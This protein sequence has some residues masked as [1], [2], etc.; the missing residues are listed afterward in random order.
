MFE[1][2]P[3][4]FKDLL[5]NDNDVLHYSSSIIFDFMNF[6]NFDIYDHY[7]YFHFN[8]GYCAYQ[9]SYIGLPKNLFIFFPGAES[10][11][12]ALSRGSDFL[13]WR[14]KDHYLNSCVFIENGVI[15]YSNKF[16]FFF[17]NFFDNVYILNICCLSLGSVPAY[18][19][20]M[21]VLENLY[22]FPKLKEIK[23]ELHGGVCL[24]EVYRKKLSLNIVK[25][26][27]QNKNIK[28]S[29]RYHIASYDIVPFTG[30]CILF[31][32]DLPSNIS[33]KMYFYHVYGHENKPVFNGKLLQN[34]CINCHASTSVKNINLGYFHKIVVLEN[35]FEINNY[36][37]NCLDIY[38]N[39]VCFYNFF[40]FLHKT[41]GIFECFANKCILDFNLEVYLFLCKKKFL[42]D[43]K[44]NYNLNYKIIFLKYII[45]FYERFL[46][47]MNLVLFPLQ[48]LYVIFY[49]LFYLLVYV[50]I[51]F[52]IIYNLICK[53]HLIL[54]IIFYDYFRQLVII[55]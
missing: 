2:F 17:S 32:N 11:S 28:I 41:Y 1:I 42:F 45:Q 9:F 15:D 55:S 30:Y 35:I 47:F 25:I 34:H 19:Y 24:P 14:N 13:F 29:F 44:Q 3:A 33:C 40:K 21:H 53:F 31:D 6:Q 50:K 16:L 5:E 8:D 4:S 39:K 12:F 43:E 51:Y 36:L 7:K 20:L 38:K 10:N 49:M 22:L 46:Y 27:E 48:L 52:L 54:L 26:C 37:N 18:F 23:L